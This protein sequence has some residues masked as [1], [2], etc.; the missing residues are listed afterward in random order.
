MIPFF[1]NYTKDLV[2]N[3]DELSLAG[4]RT[5]PSVMAQLIMHDLP[6]AKDDGGVL[7]YYKD[8]V[9]LPRGE[10]AV[11]EM[12]MKILQLYGELNSWRSNMKRE[13]INYIVGAVPKILSRPKLEWINLLNGLYDWRELKL[14][15]HNPAYH[16]TVQIP[17]AYDAASLCPHWD[18]F[19]YEVFP[20]GISLLQ[21]V[22]ALCMIPH[23]KLHKCIVLVGGGSNGKSVYL[24]AL[25]SAVG[26]SNICSVSLHQLTSNQ[27]RFN[28]SALVGKLVNIFGD[29]SPKAIDD[30]ASFKAWTGEDTISV[31]YK[32]KDRFD[33]TPFCRLIFSCKKVVTSEDD[34]SEG[35]K[36]RFLNIPF[37][38]QFASD[39]AKGAEIQY[40]LSR[41]SELSGLFNKLIPMFATLVDEGFNLTP[42]IASV[43]DNY[44]PIPKTTKA[45]LISNVVEDANGYIPTKAFYNIFTQYCPAV[46]DFNRA[47]L[48]TYMK[49]VFPSI[50][51]NYAKRLWI[52]EG[53]V[54]CYKGI[55]LSNTSYHIEAMELAYKYKTHGV[56]DDVTAQ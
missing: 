2:I 26:N 8:G 37:M 3:H 30:T 31:E 1:E 13:V 22:I 17:V 56:E 25:R 48:I 44:T 36:R 19:L 55:K 24:N 11:G 46:E 53:P 38:N 6:L 33:Y 27:D 12:Y 40:Q 10:E 35:F 54:K 34:D 43:I 49:N 7:Y 28:A 47:K 4:Y 39:P 21:E 41:P 23:M 52:G 18:Q 32:N 9:Y 14:L 5:T 16:T 15:P 45:W 29:L 20:Y 50:E 51:Y 42:E